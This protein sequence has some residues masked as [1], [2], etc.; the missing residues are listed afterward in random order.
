MLTD[1]NLGFMRTGTVIALLKAATYADTAVCGQT[2]VAHQT[3][4]CASCI[5]KKRVRAAA[6]N[7]NRNENFHAVP[8]FMRISTKKATGL[9][10]VDWLF[11]FWDCSSPQM[12]LCGHVHANEV[13]RQPPL[14]FFFWLP[15]F[16]INQSNYPKKEYIANRNRTVVFFRCVAISARSLLV[17]CQGPVIDLHQAFQ[18]QKTTFSIVGSTSYVFDRR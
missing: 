16:S 2:S 8:F 18:I 15:G 14:D 10:I 3:S 7:N 17:D 9:K 5:K 11:L 13:T 6:G 12:V 1:C 4:I